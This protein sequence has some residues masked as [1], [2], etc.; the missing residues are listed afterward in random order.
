MLVREGRM[1][2]GQTAGLTSRGWTSRTEK[3]RLGKQRCDSSLQVGGRPLPGLL[4]S[5]SLVDP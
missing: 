2:A 1:K 5:S 3:E 4:T